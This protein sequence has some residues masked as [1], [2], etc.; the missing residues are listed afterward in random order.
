MGRKNYIVLAKMADEE[1]EG[2]GKYY[3]MVVL[4]NK[5]LLL[6]ETYADMVIYIGKETV[7]AH[8]AIV[9]CRCKEIIDFPVDEKW[10]KKK[11]QEVKMKDGGV[12]SAAIMTKVLEFLYTGQV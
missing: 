8:A 2:E 11:K 3:H 10:R 4:T 1:N 6:D 12:A 7:A 9:S 5:K